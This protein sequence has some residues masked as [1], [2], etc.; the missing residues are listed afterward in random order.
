MQTLIFSHKND[1]M[2]LTHLLLMLIV[3]FYHIRNN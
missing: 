2:K 3:S 1:L